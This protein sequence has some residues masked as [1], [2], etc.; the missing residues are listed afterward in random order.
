VLRLMMDRD[1]IQIVDDQIGT[2]TW[3]ADIVRAMQALMEKDAAGIY[4]F[5]NEGVASWYDFA[6]E[7]LSVASALNYPVQ[8]RRV[9]PIPS[10]AWPSAAQRRA[11][12]VLSKEKIRR[13]LGYDIP[14]WR[15]SLRNMLEENTP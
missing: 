2:P 14:H 15:Q 5:T 3:T 8:A 1:E 10:S 6:V 7:I 4:H 9:C 13:I 12:S 11:Y